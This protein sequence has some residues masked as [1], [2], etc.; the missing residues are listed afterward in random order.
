MKNHQG[1]KLLSPGWAA[2]ANCL[3]L[4]LPG[5]WKRMGPLVCG[6]NVVIQY[7]YVHVS[8]IS[9]QG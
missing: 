8:H 5:P 4:S 2:V 6:V 1:W 9:S 7:M 3:W